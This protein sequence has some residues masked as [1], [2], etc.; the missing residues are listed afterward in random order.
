MARPARKDY[1]KTECAVIGA[2]LAGCTVALELAEAGHRV[3][4]FSKGK[5]GV[6]GN[7]YLIAGGLAAVPTKESP[8]RKGDSLALHVRETLGAGKGLN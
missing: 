3:E 1:L 5:L 7:S 6:D 2:G 4:L 8:K